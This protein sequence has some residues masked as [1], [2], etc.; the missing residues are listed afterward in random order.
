IV[1]K[2]QN[3]GET[4][5][6]IT[7]FTK[8]RGKITAICRGANRT[9]SKLSSIAQPFIQGQFLIYISTGLS[10]VQQ[11]EIIQSFR[12]MREDIIKT[13]YAAYIVELTDKLTDIKRADSFLYEQ[14]QH[15]LLRINEGDE[16][17]IPI[18]MYELKLFKKG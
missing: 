1:I 6:I 3:Y 16:L 18:I 5:K 9:R 12:S 11:G 10:T 7:I 4:H 2:T 15:T 17:I 13:A 14:L 8:E